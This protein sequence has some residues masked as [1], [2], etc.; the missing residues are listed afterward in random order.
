ML[1]IQEEIAHTI[2][3]TLRATSFAELVPP[4]RTRRTYERRRLRRCTSRDAT[5]GTSARRKASHEA[6]RYFEQAIAE[7]PRYA[8]AYAGLSDSYSLELDYRNVAVADGFA[9]AKEY[10]RKALALDETVAETHASLAWSYFIYDWNWEESRREFRRAIE[11]DPQYATA[12]HWYAFWLAAQARHGEAIAEGAARGRARPNVALDPPVDR[13]G[14]Y[15]LRA[16]LRRR[17]ANLRAR[18]RDEPNV[19]RIISGAGALLRR[20]PAAWPEAER[21]AREAVLAPP[22]VRTIGRRSPTCSRDPGS[23]S[24]RE[25]ELAELEARAQRGVCSPVSFATLH[26]G[27]ENWDAALDWMERAYSGAP[28]LARVPAGESDYG[29]PARPRAIRIRRAANEAVARSRK[30]GEQRDAESQR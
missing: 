26:L 23:A 4:A 12:H 1:A 9:L 20:W 29:W 16:S 13:A 6:I 11:L 17:G 28:R 14:L 21:A 5:S 19:G 3:E 8:Q 30:S 15:L 25:R 24:R 27:L 22:R 2:V 18:D 7:D 10:A